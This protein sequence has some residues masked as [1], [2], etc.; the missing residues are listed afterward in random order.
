MKSTEDMTLEKLKA[1]I[2]TI[3]NF[4]KPGILFRDITPLLQDGESFRFAVDRLADTLREG[5][6]TKVV[7]VEARGL[8][9]GGALAYRLGIG[10]IPVR[11][12][13]KLPWETFRKSYALEYGQDALE[14]HR[15][16][17][18][19][20]DR[21]LIVD[22]LLATGGTVRAAIDLVEGLQ[23]QVAGIV[24]LIELTEFRGRDRLK[25]YPLSSLIQF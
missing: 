8:I 7:S 21:V 19:P 10:M 2:R 24:C 11:K 9:F 12:R 20:G 4:P 14:I 23:G 15:D 22:D 6:V 1:L 13:G 16:A 3:P 5:S 25:G 18:A 17:I